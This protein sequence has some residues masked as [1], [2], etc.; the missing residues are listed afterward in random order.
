VTLGDP[1]GHIGNSGTSLEPHLHLVLLY[2]DNERSRYWSV[3]VDFLGVRA[4][5]SSE[6]A[7]IFERIA[8]LGGT[9]LW[10]P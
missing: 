8:P 4:G 9:F 6:T 3:P 5:P 1:L 2:W 7:T 10:R